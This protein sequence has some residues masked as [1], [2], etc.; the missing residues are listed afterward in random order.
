MEALLTSRV[1]RVAYSVM[2]LLGERTT[3]KTLLLV[4]HSVLRF[5]INAS[6]IGVAL[7][8]AFYSPA[9]MRR[10]RVEDRVVA[11]GVR[12]GVL[13][14]VSVFAH[15]AIVAANETWL[16]F[17]ARH[18]DGWRV[19]S[20]AEL[21]RRMRLDR[22]SQNTDPAVAKVAMTLVGIMFIALE[23]WV[24]VS[25]GQ[26]GLRGGVS[27]FVITT[28]VSGLHTVFNMTQAFMTAVPPRLVHERAEAVKGAILTEN[29]SVQ[30]VADLVHAFSVDF[31]TFNETFGHIY[32]WSS[33]CK[34]PPRLRWL[35]SKK[36]CCTVAS[37]R[38]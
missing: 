1:I 33:I 28:A 15:L 38:G 26:F 36:A 37:A 13:E 30:E 22:L 34:P 3:G 9:A 32:A 4:F 21:R 23:V 29:L 18:S 19:V 12:E 6:T 24:V 10:W 20:S 27:V 5:I 31:A 11:P 17:V 2:G 16:I 25:S 14:M 35:A 8:I 7:L